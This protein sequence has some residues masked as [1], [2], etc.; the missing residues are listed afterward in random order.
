M[1]QIK[2]KHTYENLKSINKFNN[3]KLIFLIRNKNKLHSLQIN[4]IKYYLRSTQKPFVF[5]L[6]YNNPLYILKIL[7]QF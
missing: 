3:L 6:K 1:I 4:K 2:L 5:F 7:K